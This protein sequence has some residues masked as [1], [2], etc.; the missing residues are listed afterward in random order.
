MS[1]TLDGPSGSDYTDFILHSL[2]S[3]VDHSIFDDQISE[4]ALDVFFLCNH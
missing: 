4:V 3:N 2:K 1:L